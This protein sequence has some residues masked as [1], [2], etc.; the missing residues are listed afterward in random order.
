M[1]KLGLIGWPLT[2]SLSPT[3]HNHWLEQAKIEGQYDSWPVEAG[4]VP[5][6]IAR[7]KEQGVRGCNVTVPHKRIVMDLM[8]K[9]S[10]PALSVDAVNTI[11]FEED[12]AVIGHNTDIAG[13]KNDLISQIGFDAKPKKAL[14]L[15]AGGAASAVIHAL[16]SSFSEL[17]LFVA[18]RK[19][20]SGDNY[21]YILWEDY[22]GVAAQADLII[23]ATP[24]G[25]ADDAE[26]GLNWE[27]LKES[28]FL[29]D[30]N[31]HAQ[32][33]A[34]V[35]KARKQGHGV[36]DGLGMLVGQAQEAFR[37]WTGVLPA[38]DKDFLSFVRSETG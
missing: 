24:L 12:G 13:F 25:K 35:H 32:E 4:D 29:Y 20:Q 36:C 11:C 7:L 2:Y 31:Y 27:C 16:L 5:S 26:I 18:A 8:D 6:F 19:K 14:L 3:L 22:N 30:L 34:L 37:L 1:V 10:E 15:G 21:S 9:C 38:V 28:S 23:N 33:T 17:E